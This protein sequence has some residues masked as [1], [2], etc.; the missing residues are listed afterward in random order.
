MA[1]FT[2]S[3]WSNHLQEVGK[4]NALDKKKITE[5]AIDMHIILVYYCIRYLIQ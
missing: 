2:S 5:P 1:R 3:R 4:M